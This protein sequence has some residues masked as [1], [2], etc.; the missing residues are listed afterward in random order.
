[1]AKTIGNPLSWT[2]RNLA[3]TGHHIA[4]TTLEVGGAAKMN[5]PVVRALTGDDLHAALRAGWRDFLASRTDAAFAVLVYP[6]AGIALFAL[7]LHLAL[8]PLLF[9][10]AA[11]F[12][13]LGPVA[14]VGL[15]EIS[16]RRESGLPADWRQ[17]LSVMQSPAFGAVVVLGL[18]LAALFV[19]WML[20]ARLV[21][22]VTLGPEPPASLGAFVSDVLTTPAGWAMI[23]AGIGAG[24]LFALV[25]LAISVVSFPLLLDRHVGVPVAVVTSVKVMRRSPRVVLTWGVIVAAALVI[26]TLPLFLGLVIVLPVLGHATWHL[27][28]RAIG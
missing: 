22:S 26:G 17:G 14:A 24:F 11:G 18:Y 27:Y 1:M 16:R 19:A 15:Y 20:T 13:L 12:A 25:A 21:Y 3:A 28:R 7:G 6:A 2:A 8:L 23:V 4:A 9:P 5:A 10:L